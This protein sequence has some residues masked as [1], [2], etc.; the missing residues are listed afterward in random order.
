[1]PNISSNNILKN[2]EELKNIFKDGVKDYQ[3]VY[4]KWGKNIKDWVSNTNINTTDSSNIVSFGCYDCGR[5][6][7]NCKYLKEKGEYFYSYVTKKQYK[8][9]QN[10]NSQSKSVIYLVTCTKCKKGVG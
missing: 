8:V 2:N 4:R 6:C 7:I 1:M 3:I 5:D 9:K 10:V